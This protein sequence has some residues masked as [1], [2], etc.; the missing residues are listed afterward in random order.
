MSGSSR[1][2][3]PKANAVQ[4][5]AIVR[6]SGCLVDLWELSP[7][8][9][10]DNAAH[11]EATI[12]RLFPEDA[13]ICCGKTQFDFDTRPRNAWR[14]EISDLQFIVP[15]PMSDILGRTKDNRPSKRSLTNTGPRRFLVC[16]FDHGG[17]DQ[18][19]ALLLHL[20]SLAPLVCVVHSGDNSLHGWFLVADQPDDRVLRFFRYAVSLGADPRT[21][22][23]C[24]FVRMPD[25]TGNGGRQTIYFLNFR[26]LEVTR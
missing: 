26:P 22:M 12:D 19:A 25:G 13:L 4:I 20:G 9:I 2:A 18:H 11:T 14:G 16:E 10:E 21:W 23:R 3:W 24:Q 17:T 7:V 1:L 15:S 6:Q 8:R 5:D